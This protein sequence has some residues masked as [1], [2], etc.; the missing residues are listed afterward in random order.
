MLYFS[1][2]APAICYLFFFHVVLYVFLANKWWLMISET[3]SLAI[4]TETAAAITCVARDGVA[5]Y[6]LPTGCFSPGPSRWCQQPP[7]SGYRPIGVSVKVARTCTARCCYARLRRKQVVIQ[8]CR[9]GHLPAEVLVGCVLDALQFRSL[10][11]HYTFKWKRTVSI[12]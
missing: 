12:P 10:G 2:V 7:A 4:F 3:E 11:L 1:L 5:I 6:Q 8:Q 9:R